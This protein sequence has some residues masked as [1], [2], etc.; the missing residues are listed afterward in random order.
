MENVSF[1]EDMSSFFVKAKGNKR[2]AD[3][4][5]I[6]YYYCNRSVFYSMKG[7]IQNDRWKVKGLVNYCTALIKTTTK[8]T[9]D[10]IQGEL[11]DTHYGHTT[12]LRHLCLPDNVRLSITEQLLQGFS[13]QH[14]LN[15]LHDSVETDLKWVHLLSR[16]DNNRHKKYWKVISPKYWTM[17]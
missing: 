15:N 8:Q 12:D 13:F 2:D 3:N 16:K 10:K 1:D 14:I 6:C 5:Y 17:I 9:T 7:V 4:N 11:S